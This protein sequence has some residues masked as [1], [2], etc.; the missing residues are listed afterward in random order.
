MFMD[1]FAE[2]H[3]F[4]FKTCECGHDDIDKYAELDRDIYI[5]TSGDKVG[6]YAETYH[7]MD[8]RIANGIQCMVMNSQEVTDYLIDDFRRAIEAGYE[9]NDVKGQIFAARKISPADLTIHDQRRLVETV[10]EIYERVNY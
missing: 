3:L 5:K 4:S 7:G 2:E 1:T 10:D 6:C 8:F 9:P